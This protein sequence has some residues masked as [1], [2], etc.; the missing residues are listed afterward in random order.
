M[1][2][3]QQFEN[4]VRDPGKLSLA[5]IP[6]LEA[7]LER[8]PYCQTAHLLYLKN[9]KISHNINFKKQ[10]RI[11]AAY[12]ADRAVLRKRIEKPGEIQH[13]PTPEEVKATASGDSEAAQ[14]E[15]TSGVA[16]DTEQPSKKSF[17]EQQ[18]QERHDVNIQ[19]EREESKE[20]EPV[21]K[22]Q[23]TESF[24]REK[25]AERSSLTDSLRHAPHDAGQ[26]ENVGYPYREERDEQ[27]AE[28][29]LQNDRKSKRRQ[30]IEQLRKELEELRAEKEKMESIINEETPSPKKQPEKPQKETETE[31]R[32]TRTSSPRKSNLE[33]DVSVDDY[34]EEPTKEQKPGQSSPKEVSGSQE[35]TEEPN[36]AEQTADEKKSKEEL[37][38]TFIQNEPSVKRGN[39]IFY[40]PSEAARQSVME[41]D[42]LVT[43][44]LA[45][46]YVKQGKV[47]QA[48][49]IYEKLKLKFPEKSAYFASQIKNI[50][51]NK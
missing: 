20:Q 32:D 6:Q 15:K 45:K 13:T 25:S 17:P 34:A 3:K 39:P 7:L 26:V 9:L 29:R 33:K 47:L 30:Q 50:R 19:K 16:V 49:K 1:I 8:F 51:E 46:L 10:L 21:G 2:D 42:D 48:I 35:E 28:E 5:T 22:S 27:H 18:E 14:K 23:E 24:S 43:E 44:T 38:D 40:D 41:R 36:G 11:T 4:L 37:I 12:A 31:E